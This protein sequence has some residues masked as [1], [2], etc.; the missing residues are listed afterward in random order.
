MS[1]AGA[2][3]SAPCTTVGIASE[4]TWFHRYARWGIH[5]K[6][7]EGIIE[8]GYLGW[9][10]GRPTGSD[11]TASIDWTADTAAPFNDA[12]SGFIAAFGYALLRDAR[13]P[14]ERISGLENSAR[15]WAQILFWRRI[16]LHRAVEFYGTSSPQ[17][18]SVYAHAQG[19]YGDVEAADRDVPAFEA[20]PR[21]KHIQARIS[22]AGKPC[23]EE[24]IMRSI[25]H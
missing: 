2:L 5:I 4:Y 24:T 12:S 11:G 1:K 10:S 20:L 6:A 9:S 21:W 22:M 8:N 3:H 7:K 19:K 25:F 14:V 13:E 16:L 23:E 17:Y 18:R 15:Y